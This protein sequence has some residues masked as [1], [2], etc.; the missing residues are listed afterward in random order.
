MTLQPIVPQDS[1]VYRSPAAPDALRAAVLAAGGAWL[2]VDLDGVRDKAQ[3]LERLAS[4]GRFPPGFGANWDALAD[5]LQD[6]SW[7]DSP[8]YV[9]HLRSAARAAA[10]LATEWP[11]LIEI[12]EQTA[13]YWAGRGR[14]FVALIEDDSAG[15]PTWT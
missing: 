14:P 8:A 7:C 9:L 11:T 3:L 4:A 13:D 12:L 5:S 10:A 1:G 2:E 15:L 6:L